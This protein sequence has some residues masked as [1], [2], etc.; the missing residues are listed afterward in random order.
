MNID[1]EKRI[2]VRRLCPRGMGEGGELI[3]VKKR[4]EGGRGG[5]EGGVR[6]MW[7]EV[8]ESWW[9]MAF[10]YVWEDGGGGAGRCGILQVVD[11][12]VSSRVRRKVCSSQSVSSI[13]AMIFSPSTKYFEI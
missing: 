5:K 8:G 2:I 7:V 4:E 3:A 6:E 11:S 13:T 9:D 12:K 1:K 10:V